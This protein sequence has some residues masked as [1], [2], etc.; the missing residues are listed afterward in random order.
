AGTGTYTPH[1]IARNLTGSPQSIVPTL[2]YPGA[3]GPAQST[4]A[5]LTL[6]PYA[7]MDIPLGAALALVSTP[8]PHAAIGIQYTGAPGSVIA[9]VASIEQRGELA[10][11]SYVQNVGNNFAGS[12]AH[13]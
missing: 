2:E 1:I 7:T 6:S 11:S 12:G 9:E 3:N 5:A 13:A 8:V 10:V 4:L